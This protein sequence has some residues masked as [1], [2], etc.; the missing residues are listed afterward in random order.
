[1]SAELDGLKAAVT[2]ANTKVNNLGTA[3][4][5]A[6]AKLNAPDTNAA[7][8]VALTQ[9]VQNMGQQVQAAS[10]ALNNAVNPPP[11]A[12]PAPAPAA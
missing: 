12:E 8:L 1:M 10:D 4:Q 9:T 6:L 3:V 2:D 7:D 11:V 5:A